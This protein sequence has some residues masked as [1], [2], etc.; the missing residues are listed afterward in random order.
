M[1]TPLLLDLNGIKNLLIGLA[2]DIGGFWAPYE[3]SALQRVERA[4]AEF[5]N[6]SKKNFQQASLE[7]NIDAQEVQLG[8]NGKRHIIGTVALGTSVVEMLDIFHENPK[9]FTLF[10]FSRKESQKAQNRLYLNKGS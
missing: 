8:E 6:L 7:I 3:F 10:R 9:V 5:E 4:K 2:V 1:K